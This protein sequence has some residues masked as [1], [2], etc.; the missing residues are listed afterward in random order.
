M[1]KF[2]VGDKVRVINNPEK[3][4]KYYN[5]NSGVWDDFV[6]EMIEKRGSVLTIEGISEN[7]KYRVRETY[8]NWTDEMFVDL[9]AEQH[10][11]EFFVIHRD[12][13][14]MTAE[15]RVNREVIKS[16]KATCNPSDTF[17]LYTG[18]KLAFDRLIGR[19]EPKPAHRFKVGDRVVVLGKYNGEVSAIDEKNP[20][21]AIYLVYCP[22]IGFHSG[23]EHG[24][25][26]KEEHL[27]NCTW[28][29]EEELSPTP[30]PPKFYTGKVFCSGA[31]A[32]NYTA[33]VGRVFS[34]V[35]GICPELSRSAMFQYSDLTLSRSGTILIHGT[36]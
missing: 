18:A 29:G 36:R 26:C 21:D 15:H 20:H 17:D 23:G 22:A 32:E 4:K 34:F 12:G 16:A 11:R 28:R 3:G 31:R 24:V 7:G 2:K 8:H 27:G 6:N 1:S 30:E 13:N 5:E 9:A 19:E 14:T 10:H 35:D 33:R 25:V